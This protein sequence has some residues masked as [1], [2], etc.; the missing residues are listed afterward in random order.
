MKAAGESFSDVIMRF[1]GER[2]NLDALRDLPPAVAGWD[3]EAFHEMARK[4][5][6]ENL[7][8]LAPPKR[9]GGRNAV[10]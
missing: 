3:D 9:A 5:D 2:K 1:I 7:G 4:K 8:T 10:R 6:I